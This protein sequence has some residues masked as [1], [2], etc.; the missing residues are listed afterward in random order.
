MF[1]FSLLFLLITIVSLFFFFFALFLLFNIQKKFAP[2]YDYLG[3]FATRFLGL[4]LLESSFILFKGAFFHLE[5][6]L[7][8]IAFCCI[9]AFGVIWF[10]MTPPNRKD[11]SSSRWRRYN[12]LTGTFFGKMFGGFWAFAVLWGLLAGF[13]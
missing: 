8:A 6:S 1:K 9:M 11:G 2:L 13:N 12:G 10:T 4:Y 7:L 5:I 3:K